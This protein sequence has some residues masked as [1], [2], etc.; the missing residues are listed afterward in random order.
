[1]LP[2]G[3]LGGV[4]ISSLREQSVSAA[5]HNL[6]RVVDTTRFLETFGAT[7]DHVDELLKVID[8]LS[9]LAS[10]FLT[11]LMKGKDCYYIQANGNSP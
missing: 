1:M 2:K 9:S 4:A 11:R 5:V 10:P 7:V 6:A 8:L 3:A